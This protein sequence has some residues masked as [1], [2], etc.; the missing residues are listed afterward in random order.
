MII[1]IFSYLLL[2]I[3]VCF[4]SACTQDEKTKNTN[5]PC[6][7]DLLKSLC[8]I[9][10]TANLDVNATDLCPNL[11]RYHGDL[12]ST[13]A[14][15]Q[16]CA[17]QDQCQVVCDLNETCPY[18]IKM[19]VNQQVVCH[20]QSTQTA[21]GD[22]ICAIPETVNTCPI[23][24]NGNLVCMIGT[25]RCYGDLL[26]SCNLQSRWDEPIAC[27][28]GYLCNAQNNAQASCVL[29]S[30]M[31]GGSQD[32]SQDGFISDLDMSDQA[33]DETCIINEVDQMVEVSRQL[34]CGDRCPNLEMLPILAGQMIRGSTRQMNEQPVKTVQISRSFYIS[35]TE[36]T[37]ANYQA[38]VY[39]RFCTEPLDFQNNQRCT[40]NKDN[41]QNLPINC[42]TWKQARDFAKWIG[43][44][45]PTETQWEY[46]AK[47]GACENRTYPWGERIAACLLANFDQSNQMDE[48]LCHPDFLNVC[49]LTMGNTKDGACDMLGNVSE[50]VL[51]EYADTY[52]GMPLNE[53]PRCMDAPRCE[54]NVNR[55]VRGGSLFDEIQTTTSRISNEIN[56]LSEGIG[57]R[58]VK[59]W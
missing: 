44:D 15:D 55:V 46:V 1:K 14:V 40:W 38:C 16:V 17:D 58:V 48:Q 7:Q 57:F 31:T 45:L 54:R 56:N 49:S 2:Q 28:S 4:I 13:S 8:P 5:P 26:Q 51:D 32:A 3:L 47:G 27:P 22:G 20:E 34:P 41:A 43:G 23:D 37:V 18:G 50:F 19:V 39:A 36:I 52:A 21:C 11:L 59:P 33:I 10:S 29:D 35:K 24:C 42:I 30:T 25:S 53:S 9:N 6:A 12:T